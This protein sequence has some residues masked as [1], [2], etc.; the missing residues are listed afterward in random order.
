MPHSNDG[1]NMERVRADLE[2]LRAENAQLQM[3]L[4]ALKR[5]PP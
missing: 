3:E 4:K 1:L 5:K 2:T